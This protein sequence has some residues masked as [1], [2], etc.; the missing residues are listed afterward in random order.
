MP[1]ITRPQLTRVLRE[2][3]PRRLWTRTELWDW[4]YTTQRRSEQAK[5]A[6][7]ARRRL[8]Q[9]IAAELRCCT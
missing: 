3:L 6:H 2:L 8:N 7:A 1:Q 9:I 4:L 5:Q